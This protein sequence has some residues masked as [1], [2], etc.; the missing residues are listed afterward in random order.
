MRQLSEK[1][2]GIFADIEAMENPFEHF[3]PPDE[4]PPRHPFGQRI[5]RL[6][7]EL[8]E[9]REAAERRVA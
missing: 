3:L 4:P 2:K 1:L 8:A 9:E 7:E 5:P 6:H